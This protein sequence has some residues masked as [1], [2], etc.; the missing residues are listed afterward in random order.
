MVLLYSRSHF[1]WSAAGICIGEGYRRGIGITCE[2]DY[3]KRVH[4]FDNVV[5]L[6]SNNATPYFYGGLADRNMLDFTD[7]WL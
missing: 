1:Q 7:D 2:R 6:A 3:I 4:L 5:T